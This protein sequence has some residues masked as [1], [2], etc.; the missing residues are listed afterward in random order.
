MRLFA[1][2]IEAQEA[3]AITKIELSCL[4]TQMQLA[5]AGLTSE[6]ARSFVEA[7]QS[8]DA[9]MARLSFSEIAGEAEPPIAERLV[10]SNALRRQ[11]HRERQ[12]ALRNAHRR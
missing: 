11:R 8:V 2:Q 6:A 12:I 4:E 3:Q 7:L 1:A 9:L 10:S 5:I